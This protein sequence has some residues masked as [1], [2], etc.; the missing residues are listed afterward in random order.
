MIWHLDLGSQ[1]TQWQGVRIA[2]TFS[3]S[4][5]IAAWAF[6]AGFASCDRNEIRQRT[7][8]REQKEISAVEMQQKAEKE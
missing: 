4:N 8:G 1:E 3:S 6:T 2:R 7:A 5:E